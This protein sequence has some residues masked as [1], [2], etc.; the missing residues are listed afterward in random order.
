MAQFRDEEQY[1]EYDAGHYDHHME[2]RLV[3]VLD[4][5]VQDSVNKAL[6][7]ALRPFAQPIFKFG[8]RHFSAGSGNPIPV[9]V[10]IN[11]LG[12][13]SDDLLDQTLTLQS[14]EPGEYALNRLSK[15]EIPTAPYL[16]TPVPNN[17]KDGRKILTSVF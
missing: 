2:E 17:I 15:P 5:H 10:N 1:G 14:R 4:F 13:S 6:V 3:E 12:R 16:K 11:E 8:F 7:K 9:E